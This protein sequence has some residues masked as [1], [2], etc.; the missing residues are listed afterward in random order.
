MTWP[1]SGVVLDANTCERLALLARAGRTDELLTLL[2]EASPDQVDG[3]DDSLLML[4]SYHGHA[5]TVG[6]L[7]A[8]GA[9]PTLRNGRGLAPLDAAAL[10]GSVRAIDALLDGG[11]D[12]EDEGPDGRTAL[13]WAAG[14]DHVAAVERLLARGAQRN[15]VDRAGFDAPEHARVMGAGAV[16][17]FFRGAA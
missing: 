9:D 4:A 17:R 7:L 3:S 8:R 14:F 1:R 12:V 6:A 5:D 13:M 15:H 16:Q 10:Q 11:A 2:G